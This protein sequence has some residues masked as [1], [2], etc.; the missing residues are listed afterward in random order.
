MKT[1]RVPLLVG[2]CMLAVIAAAFS[3]VFWLQKRQ[4]VALL[5]PLRIVFEGSVS[6]LRAG[7][8]VTF[9][10]VKIGEV[11]SVRLDNPQRIVVLVMIDHDAPVRKDTLVRIESLGLTGI[12]AVALKGGAE[13]APPAERDA[14]GMPTLSV[15]TRTIQDL[16]Q[17]LQATLQNVN[18]LVDDNRET[19]KN[20][21]ANI[22]TFMAVVSKNAD[23]IDSIYANGERV[24]G[25]VN[26]DR[27]M[28]V[29]NR[30]PVEKISNEL[31]KTVVEFKEL[32]SNYEKRAAALNADKLQMQADVGRAAANLDRNPARLIFGS[33]GNQSPSTNSPAPVTN[34]AGQPKQGRSKQ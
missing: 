10:G 27:L 6:G 15:D 24:M 9:N 5:T 12:T 25:F 30:I 1:S 23:R 2:F 29:W 28:A 3:S 18:R 32:A 33:S 34:S 21:V 4:R 22:A 31:S 7:R 16:S 8:D 26:S 14:D 11:R 17:S 20:S 13:N 19:V